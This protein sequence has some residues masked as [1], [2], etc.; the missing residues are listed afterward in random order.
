MKLVT[1]AASAV[2]AIVAVAV[3]ASVLDGSGDAPAQVVIEPLTTVSARPFPTPPPPST[4]LGRIDARYGEAGP[5]LISCYDVNGDGT[6]DA[7]DDEA[8]ANLNIPLLPGRA[9]AADGVYADYYAGGPSDP[10]GYACGA[11]DPDPLLIVVAASAGSNLL[12]ASAG[13]SLGLIDIINTLQPAAHREGIATSLMLSTSAIDGA[14]MPQTNMER[15]LAEQVRRRLEALPCLR[16]VIFGHS[17]GGA[18]VTS[19]TAALDEAYGDRMLGVLI[20]RTVALYD[21]PAREIPAR[22]RVLNFYQLNEGWHGWPLALDNVSD[23]DRSTDLAP[24][25]PSDGG[26]APAPVSHKTLDDSPHVQE[27]AVALV[28]RW[29]TE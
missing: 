5:E 8:G 16:A 19:V 29:A 12:D 21:R 4:W 17:H 23:I 27:A 25:A 13:E 20:D 22:T 28:L 14:E 18:T 11:G 24:I 6:I 9:C 10:A 26:G 15:W 3:L 7:G 2:A 1:G